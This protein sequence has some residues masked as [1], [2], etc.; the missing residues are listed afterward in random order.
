MKYPFNNILFRSTRPPRGF[1]LIE[2]LASLVILALI[3]SSTFIII[4]RCL[5]STAE[6]TL[7]MQAFQV[8][9]E[10]METLLSKQKVKEQVNYGTSKKYPHINWETVVE[11]FDEPVKSQM[12]VRA[13]CSAYYIDREGIEQKVELT[14]WLTNVSRRQMIQILEQMEKREKI[15]N[16]Q[17][18]PSLSQA[19]AY[20]DVP[21]E[22]IQMWL[23]NGM[24][25]AVNGAFIKDMLD[26]YKNSGGYPSSNNIAS[27]ESM[28]RFIMESASEEI[29]TMPSGPQSPSQPDGTGPST[30]ASIQGQ[31]EG[32]NFTDS[33]QEK[34]FQNMSIEEL[35]ELLM[36]YQKQ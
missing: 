26:L 35:W 15:L 8:C 1:T 19:A 4:D 27:V 23:D 24:P 7:K 34:N 36:N 31:P 5:N 17:L 6:T 11:T 2:I 22:T 29:T 30:S 10:N 33:Y 9:R 13:V 16:D 20:A 28:Y 32:T 21:L 12:W 18:I 25:T 14:H 3:S